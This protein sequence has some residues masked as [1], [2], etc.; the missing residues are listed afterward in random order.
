MKIKAIW[1]FRGDAAKLGAG[2]GR[3]RAGDTFTNVEPEYAH[4]LI[5]KGLVEEVE[6]GESA[7]TKRPSQGLSPAQLKKA[8]TEKGIAIPEGADKAALAALLD[9]AGAQ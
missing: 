8:L 5:G 2:T 4:S 3:V 6:G 9:E 7:T 1:G